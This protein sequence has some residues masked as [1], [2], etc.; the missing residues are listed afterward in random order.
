[1]LK[2]Q[3]LEN[4]TKSIEMARSLGQTVLE[5][6]QQLGHINYQ[7]AQEAIGNLQSKLA[8][9]MDGRSINPGLSLLHTSEVQEALTQIATY[10]NKVAQIFRHNNQGLIKAVEDA[11]DQSQE[12]WRI[13]VEDA[14]SKAPAGSEAYV[15]VFSN[16]FNSV[17]KNFEQVRKTT[18]EAF[19]RFEENVET[20]FNSTQ[21]R[22][23]RGDKET[24]M[25]TKKASTKY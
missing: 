24:K 9:L 3:F 8:E 6:A 20:A 17:M 2:N 16:A 23:E 22:P 18:Q 10:Q 25:S 15:K 21:A 4:Q 13:M 11:I 5:N 7:A 12:D 1:M 19:H 14:S